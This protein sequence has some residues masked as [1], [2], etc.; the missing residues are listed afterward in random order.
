MQLF[1][2]EACI[3]N[4]TF[5]LLLKLT[6]I[7]AVCLDCNNCVAY[8]L[9]NNNIISNFTV[10]LGRVILFKIVQLWSA[11]RSHFKMVTLLLI[12]GLFKERSRL[13][14]AYC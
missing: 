11:E 1:Q 7:T 10:S 14:I 13:A 4:R 12:L 9:D 3:Q 2:H 5:E 6:Y 8:L